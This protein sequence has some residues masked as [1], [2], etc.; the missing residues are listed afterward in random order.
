MQ[1]RLK[2]AIEAAPYFHPKLSATAI[3][4]PGEGFDAKLKAAIA[5][6]RACRLIEHTPSEPTI[7]S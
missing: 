5:R 1:R 4:S 3:V 2:A 7:A 6:S